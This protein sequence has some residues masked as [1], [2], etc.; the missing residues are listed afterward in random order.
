MARKQHIA[1]FTTASLPWMTGTAVNPLFRAAYLAKEG[2]REVSL[3]IPWLSIKDQELVYPNK[4]TFKIPLEQEAFVRKWLEERTGMV[5]RFNISFYAGKFSKEKRS[6][7]PVGDITETIPDEVA[8]I[9]V[10]EEPEH[11]TWYHHGKRWKVKFRRVIGVVHTNYLAYVKREKNGLIQAFLLKHVNAWVIDIYCHKVVRLSAATQDLPRSIICNVHGVN[12]KFLEVGK[13]KQEQQQRGEQA[14]RKGAY[15]IG[16]MIWSKGYSELLQLL[17]ENQDELSA[18]QM[19]LYGNGEDSDQV[20]ES[21][22]KLELDIRIYPGRDHVDPIFH[23]YKVFINPSTTDV[24]CTTTAEALAMGKIVICANHPSNDFFKRFPNCH[25]YNTGDEFVKLTLKALAEE[26]V[27]LTDEL[28]H[29]LSWEAATERFVRVAELDFAV[30]EKPLP[31]A[32]QRFMYISSDEVRKNIE[33]ASAIIHHTVS[34]IEAARCA[35]GAI[36]KTLRPDEQQ[37]RELGLAFPGQ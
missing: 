18:L 33:E 34:G 1:I 6:I 3:V 7:L 19:E 12:P 23:E 13:Y 17:S 29:E 22:K 24:V 28:R 25:M 20:R 31:S 35:F 15:Y 36:P 37:C 8:D 4:I 9:A 14:F 2:D 30:S 11:L 21:A 32:S 27:P 26:P 10:L 5:S 16:K